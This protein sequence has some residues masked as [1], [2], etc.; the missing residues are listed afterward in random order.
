M[1]VCNEQA[2]GFLAALIEFAEWP[3]AFRSLL[4][5]LDKN[6]M[7]RSYVFKDMQRRLYRQGLA[8]PDESAFGWSISPDVHEK[9]FFKILRIVN[10]DHRSA[11]FLCQRSVDDRVTTGKMLIAAVLASDYGFEPKVVRD[12]DDGFTTK[13]NAFLLRRYFGV[14]AVPGYIPFKVAIMEAIV[15]PSA[16]INICNR[17]PAVLQDLGIQVQEHEIVEV[18]RKCRLL[19]QALKGSQVPINGMTDFSSIQPPIT[20]ARLQEIKLHLARAYL[21]QIAEISTDEEG[22]SHAKD[23]LSDQPFHISEES[24]DILLFKKECQGVYT[25]LH[26][27]GDGGPRC[28]GEFTYIDEDIL[29]KLDHELGDRRHRGIDDIRTAFA[30]GSNS[31]EVY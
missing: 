1:S 12:V 31:Y 9:A 27:S 7:D 19:I 8:I 28:M 3:T 30:L 15:D 24:A 17:S 2:G 25:S 21:H 6:Q 10:Y 23:K 16:R 13:L 26:C 11:H 4:H 20:P 5:I 18:Q 22:F 29:Q 14:W